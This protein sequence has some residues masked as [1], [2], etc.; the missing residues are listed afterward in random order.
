M[1]PHAPHAR[2]V[3]LELCELDLELALGTSCVLGEDVEDQLRAIDDARAEGVLQAALL[4]GV[5]LVVD[6]QRFGVGVL[7]E[8]LQLLELALTHVGPRIGS[9]TSL[10]ELADRRDAGGAQE[11]AQLA[12]LLALVHS[13][14]QHG[15]DESALGLRS[16]RGVRLVVGHSAIMPGIRP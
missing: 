2:E 6:D 5:E 7:H 11:F 16:G 12:Q 10:H 9:L 14:A 8:P 15:D 4:P 3:V 13:G 1:L